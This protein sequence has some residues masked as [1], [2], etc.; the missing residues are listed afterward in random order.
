VCRVEGQSSGVE[1][2]LGQCDAVEHVLSVGNDEAYLT[3]R[4]QLEMWELP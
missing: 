3:T 1:V 4:W 2:G